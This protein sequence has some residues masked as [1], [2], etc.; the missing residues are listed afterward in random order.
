M[1]SPDDVFGGHEEKGTDDIRSPWSFGI[2]A[3]SDCFRCAKITERKTA[4][5]LYMSSQWDYYY[6]YRC[7]GWF[8]KPFKEKYVVLPVTDRKVIKR[9]TWMYTSQMEALHENRKLLER[10]ESVWRGFERRLS[11]V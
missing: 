5:L 7:R 10:M 4:E 9:L 11:H 1:D 6:C 8:K 3:D 2:Y